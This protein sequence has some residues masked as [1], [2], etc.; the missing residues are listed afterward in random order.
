M[1]C[2]KNDIAELAGWKELSLIIFEVL[3][4]NI[5]SWA[6]S[7]AFIESAKKVDDNF[8]RS[9]IIDNFEFADISSFHHNLE[10]L[11]NDLAAWADENLALATAFSICN[12]FKGIG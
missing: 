8:A 6:D 2:S 3:Q 9:V 1:G 12:C 11:D 10:E 5:E 7:D 4:F